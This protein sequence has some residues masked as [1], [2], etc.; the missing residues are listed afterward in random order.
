MPS[1]ST[2]LTFR[3]T[4]SRSR[5]RRMT[6]T[7]GSSGITS[8]VRPVTLGLEP[9]PG[10][11]RGGLLRRLLR[12]TLPGPVRGTADDDGR[13]EPL[14]VVGALVADLV[15]RQLVGGAGRQLLE[16]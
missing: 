8:P 1:A 4:I 12:A 3:P 14:V 6:S 7:S 16:A 5:S 15:A 9:L 2:L 13:E 11:P 10:D